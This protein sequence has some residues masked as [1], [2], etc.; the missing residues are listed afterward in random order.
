[1]NRR[2]EDVTTS[3]LLRGN[4]ATL[5]LAILRDGP[6]HGYAIASEIAQRSD[7]QFQF[8]QGTLYP[9]LHELERD[10]HI[11]SEWEIPDG[12]RPR[13]VY[14]LTESGKREVDRRLQA[15]QQFTEVMAR[16][17]GVATDEA[18]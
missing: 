3:Q 4:T 16:V 18:S 8:K 10:G 14:T 12:E 7:H 9:L 15:W 1:M 13:R 6:A 2:H 11:A 17:T 5:V